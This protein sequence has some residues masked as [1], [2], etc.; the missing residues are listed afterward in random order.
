MSIPILVL[1]RNLNESGVQ[2]SKE[3]K[4]SHGVQSTPCLHYCQVLRSHATKIVCLDHV[5]SSSLVMSVARLEKGEAFK[6]L[7]SC[8]KFHLTRATRDHGGRCLD[9][10][11]TACNQEECKRG[12]V[13]ILLINLVESNNFDEL[14]H[15]A[16]PFSEVHLSCTHSKHKREHE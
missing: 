7:E 14:S 16:Q 5:H 3:N 15:T 6:P 1:Q 9:F 13:R 2:N 12:R 11:K 10:W 8:G 4:W